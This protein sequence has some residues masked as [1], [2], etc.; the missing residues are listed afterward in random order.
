MM[1]DAML[2][3]LLDGAA[4]GGDARRLL[5]GRGGGVPGLGMVAIE[6]FDPV[7]LVTL[8]GDWEGLDGFVAEAGRRDVVDAVVVG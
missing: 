1:R 4:A 5:H 3:R 2:S 6:W 8:Y 7:L